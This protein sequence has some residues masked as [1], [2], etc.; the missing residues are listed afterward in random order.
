MAHSHSQDHN[1][2]AYASSAGQN[3]GRLGL[4]LCLTAAFMVFEAV[5][6][7]LTNSLALLAD[8]GHML[9]DVAGLSLA[10][11]AVWFA[12]RPATHQR[13]YGYYRLE[14]L[15]AM[16]NALFLIFVAGFILYE[17]YQR[18]MDPPEVQSLPLVLVASGGLVVNLVSVRLLMDA[19]K[20]SLNMKG[21]FLEVVSDGLGS[22]GAI[23]A[24]LI[25][26]T[27]GW[28]YAD[29]LFAA[30]IGVFILPRTWGLLRSALSI[31]L[32]GTPASVSVPH[33]TEHILAMPG[34]RGVHDLHVWTI[35]SGFIAM[36][37]HIVV[38]D[39]VDHD[40]LIVDVRHLMQ[41]EFEIEHVTL[42]I[43]TQRL[44]QELE[45][46]CL[47]GTSP[48]YAAD[49]ATLVTRAVHH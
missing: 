2:H 20:Q 48:C 13:T 24:G 28:R 19:S 32:E 7:Y 41:D 12:K 9:T 30:A 27:T 35:T 39:E 26:L 47:P 5:A 11:A 36:S 1:S 25:M 21:A 49:E 14:I 10:L 18:L 43:E 38:E 37:G 17:S 8:A 40:H 15:A 22:A 34:V 4:V 3:Q 23:A 45:Q 44:E 42:Q 31:L 6:G 16:L 46:P 29:P 33:M